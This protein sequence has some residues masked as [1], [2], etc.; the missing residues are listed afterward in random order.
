MVV[1]KSTSATDDA[2]CND[3]SLFASGHVRVGG[4]LR[5]CLL[6]E[7]HARISRKSTGHNGEPLPANHASYREVVVSPQRPVETWNLK[8]GADDAKLM[9]RSE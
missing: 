5:A 3:P 1:V 2:S 9:E 7:E 6:E 4:S 8:S